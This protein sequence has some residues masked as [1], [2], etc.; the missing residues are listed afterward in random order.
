MDTKTRDAIQELVRS[1]WDKEPYYGYTLSEETT[2]LCI[3]LLLK[4]E[5]CM[6]M[7]EELKTEVNKREEGNLS[8]II[9]LDMK[10]RNEIFKQA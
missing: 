6:D 9:D 5:E 10:I 4:D 7:W 2:I 3:E 1:Y 8:K